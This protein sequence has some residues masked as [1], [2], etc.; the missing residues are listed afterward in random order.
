MSERGQVVIYLGCTIGEIAP[1]RFRRT[2]TV[3]FGE[4]KV[5]QHGDF[6]IREQNIR[7]SGGRFNV[8]AYS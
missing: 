6:F 2:E 7:G 8:I 5:N 1:E 4:S 3:L